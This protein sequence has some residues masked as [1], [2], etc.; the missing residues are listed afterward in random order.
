MTNTLEIQ[1]NLQTYID[2]FSL[3]DKL[4]WN[5]NH[6][7]EVALEDPRFRWKVFSSQNR[8]DQIKIASQIS[9]SLQD[10]K[11]V[12]V[13]D[14]ALTVMGG[15]RVS[16][17][18]FSKIRAD[19]SILWSELV[20]REYIYPDGAY[21]A[22]AIA[23]LSGMSSLELSASFS[24]KT[25]SIL[26]V[27]RDNQKWVPAPDSVSDIYQ[28]E[29]K[30]LSSPPPESDG[31]FPPQLKETIIF[32]SRNAREIRLTPAYRDIVP[33]RYVL[34][35]ILDKPSVRTIWKLK[36][37]YGGDL[38]QESIKYGKEIVGQ[39]RS[40]DVTYLFDLPLTSLAVS[41]LENKSFN[42]SELFYIGTNGL[43]KERMLEIIET[44]KGWASE[45]RFI[46]NQ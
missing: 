37:L 23:A 7:L 26:E 24:K 18:S 5:R 32:G 3:A 13:S 29:L 19:E 31:S 16:M 1:R 2:K 42:E 15:W 34:P 44:L 21:K 46:R 28:R 41:I 35:D 43:Y 33:D 10:P 38:E 40:V 45:R 12:S 11:P 8:I 6:V 9:L 27:F 14:A 17:D 22:R 25:N 4:L 36:G 39:F 20:S 30:M